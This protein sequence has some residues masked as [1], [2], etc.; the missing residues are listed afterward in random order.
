VLLD[1][2]DSCVPGTAPAERRDGPNRV[3]VA[4]EYDLDRTV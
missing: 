3:G 4:L 1:M 2:V